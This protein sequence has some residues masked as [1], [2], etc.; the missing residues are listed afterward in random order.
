MGLTAGALGA[1]SGLFGLSKLWF[2]PT[3]LAALTYYNYD[4]YDPENQ[5]IDAKNI[6]DEYDFIVIGG[7]SAGSVVS[8]RL[9]ENKEWSVL[10]LEAGGQESILTD[11]PVLSL[12][13]HGSRYDWKYK[14]EP[15]DSACQAMINKRCCWTR[16][17]VI[18]GSSVLNTMLYIRGNRRDFDNWERMG[19]PGWGYEDILPYFKKSEDQRNPY[20]AKNDRYHSTGGLLTIQDSP[21]NTP[22]GLAFLQAG[23]EMGYDIV[24]VNG[25][26]Q[27]GFALF[28]YTMRRGMRS[29]AAKAFINPFRLRSNFHT[30]LNAF[31]TK[32]IMDPQTNRAVAVEFV[33]DGHRRVVRARKE[34][35]VSGGTINSAQLLMLSGIGPAEHLLEHG[36]QPLVD[37]PGV[38]GNVMDH[39]A[40]GGIAFLIDYP[41]S[42]V[43]NRVVNLNTALRY[44]ISGDGP[45][46]S[47]SGIETVGFIT[48]KY[49]NQSDDWPDIEF[50]LTSTSTP[51][52]GGT[53]VRRAH[54]LTDSFYNEVFKE[55]NN[56]DL[57]GV[58]PMMLRP[59]SRGSIRLRSKN[60]YHYPL[61]YHNYLTHPDDVRVLREGVKASLAFAE[62][63]AMKRFGARYHSKPLPN[64]K[65]YPLYTDEY[66]DCYVRQ[67]TM[68]IYHMSGSCKMGPITDPYAVVD[69]TLRVYGTQGLR[70]IDA[71][72]MP[73]ITS[74]NINA[75][76]IMIGEK[77][78]DM[79]TKY[80][81]G[82]E[83][84]RKRS[85][86]ETNV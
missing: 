20:L 55:I 81:K 68:T 44:A 54:C 9:S 16:G 21:W 28:Q 3:F 72:I 52:D 79:I 43:M 61:I 31:A 11:V 36:I 5:P 23:E 15:Q 24:D 71:S 41:I 60:P 7:G 83:K 63:Q 53:N 65:H 73:Q 74:G 76:V 37:L 25:E 58:F 49:G 45:L 59:K 51:S 67:Y 10:L 86:N 30:A 2:I 18:G 34:I 8:S 26:Q 46:T 29:S 4:L 48:T 14:T 64:C 85:A 77:G 40:V 69:P 38:G 12:Y 47:S 62:T 66:W 50:M 75:P 35:I 42:L 33:K 80:W 84:R 27:T 82:Y 1:A 39:I 19:N 78:A 22:I 57:F 70:V 13:L 32:I 56:H 17:K 6:Q